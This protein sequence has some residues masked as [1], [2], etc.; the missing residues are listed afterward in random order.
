M[1]GRGTC[2][3]PMQGIALDGLRSA[4]RR[5]APADVV[6]PRQAVCSIDDLRAFRPP[7]SFQRGQRHTVPHKFISTRSNLF[8]VHT[9]SRE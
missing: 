1:K 3:A 4:A 9:A 2:R 6:R 7:V 8:M 5:R